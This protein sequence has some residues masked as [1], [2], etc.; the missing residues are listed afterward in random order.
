[1]RPYAWA[2]CYD[3]VM[4]LLMML[5]KDSS[6]KLSPT[7]SDEAERIETAPFKIRGDVVSYVERLDEEFI[8]SLRH[9]DPHTPDYV[10]R[11]V[12]SCLLRLNSC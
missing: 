11:F 5:E 6:V 8:K 9:I 1:M 4:K 3:D 12:I 7:L 10:F 2:N